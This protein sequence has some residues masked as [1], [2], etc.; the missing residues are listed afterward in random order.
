[1]NKLLIIGKKFV[2]ENIILKRFIHIMISYYIQPI[3]ADSLSASVVLNT[4]YEYEY[5]TDM[6][7]YNVIAIV[8]ITMLS[9]GQSYKISKSLNNA[10]Q[11]PCI[12]SIVT[13]C[14]FVWPLSLPKHMAYCIQI[15]EK[16]LADHTFSGLCLT[17][18]L[19]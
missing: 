18:Y 12:E 4:C 8:I 14:R 15:S 11:T 1:M 2:K 3:A 7:K 6:S 10:G 19:I 5:S 17:R 13:N 16:A 9:N